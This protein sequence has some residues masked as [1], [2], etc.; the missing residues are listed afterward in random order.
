MY[1][2]NTHVHVLSGLEPITVGKHLLSRPVPPTRFTEA[3][4]GK[5]DGRTPSDQRLLLPNTL[6]SLMEAKLDKNAVQ[7]EYFSIFGRYRYPCEAIS[8]S[9]RSAPICLVSLLSEAS[10]VASLIVICGSLCFALTDFQA[11]L[12]QSG[13]FHCPDRVH[14]AT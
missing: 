14:N 11:K 3:W 7:S 4:F 1:L 13:A 9:E 12:H 5:K 6:K 2:Q 10:Q 8:G